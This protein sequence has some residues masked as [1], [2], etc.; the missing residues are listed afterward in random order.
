MVYRRG[1]GRREV[2]RLYDAMIREVR[3]EVVRRGLSG[4]RLAALAGVAEGLVRQARRPGWAPS[5]ETLLACDEALFAAAPAPT[6]P[7]L[8]IDRALLRRAVTGVDRR[9]RA[10]GSYAEFRL[11]P[12]LV[13]A[14]EPRQFGPAAR[15][16][17]ARD[18]EEGAAETAAVL[19]ALAP[20]CAVH[21]FVAD[22]RAPERWFA[23]I[24]DSS[25]GYLGGR[26]LTGIRV[27]ENPDPLYV[28]AMVADY[29]AAV[30]SGEPAFSA[31]ERRPAA[32]SP[33]SFLRFIQSLPELDGPAKFVIL[34][35]PQEPGF[36]LDDMGD[37]VL[38]RP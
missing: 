14:L 13:A 8:A 11:D 23:E 21:V 5:M 30:R 36:L 4:R 27:E 2:G 28:E 31:V 6:A 15:Y 22:G 19:K 26:D 10:G 20:Q 18:R 38:G 37:L 34:S 35:S 1:L 29:R 9:E 24:W 3:E 16:L 12:R 17:A 33:R 7:L 25:T 32:D